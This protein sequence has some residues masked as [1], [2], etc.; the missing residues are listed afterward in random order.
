M[1]ASHD[2]AGLWTLAWRRLRADRIAMAALA[3][4]A[5][6]LLLVLLSGLGLVADDWEREVAVNYA[7]PGFVGADPGARA[8][9]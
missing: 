5:G 2:S 4:V 3:V 1:T 6:C 7:P 8:L 9:A